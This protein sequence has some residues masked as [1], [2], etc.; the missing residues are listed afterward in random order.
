MSSVNTFPSPALLSGDTDNSRR[1]PG[2]F[3]PVTGE[4]PCGPQTLCEKVFRKAGGR[5]SP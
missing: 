4:G 2:P 1:P 5:N 3:F